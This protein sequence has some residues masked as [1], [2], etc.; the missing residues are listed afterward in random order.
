MTDYMSKAIEEAKMSLEES[1]IPIGAV[2]VKD[3]KVVGKV[4]NKRVQK[5]DPN[6]ARGDRLSARHR[7]DGFLQRYGPIFYPDALLSMFWSFN[8][9][10]YR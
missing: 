10:R 4:H 9:V 3:N 8:P 2:L 5:D 7:E 1:G 6:P